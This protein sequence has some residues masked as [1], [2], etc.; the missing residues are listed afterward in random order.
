MIPSRQ[1]NSFHWFRKMCHT[2]LSLEGL[3][4]GPSLYLQLI[5]FNISGPLNFSLSLRISL[6]SLHKIIQKLQSQITQNEGIDVISNSPSPQKTGEEGGRVLKITF[7]I[8]RF[9]K[10]QN[11][12]IHVLLG[13]CRFF[14]ISLPQTLFHLAEE[15]LYFWRPEKGNKQRHTSLAWYL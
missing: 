11:N 3:I 4:Q 2:L 1:D 6:G 7:V 12:F 15:K 13:K 8:G 10:M 14:F 9:V 5:S